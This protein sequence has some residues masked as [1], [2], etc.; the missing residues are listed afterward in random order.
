MGFSL[1][2]LYRS[3]VFTASAKL[4]AIAIALLVTVPI[5]EYIQEVLTWPGYLDVL[6]IVVEEGTE[7][8]AIVL[9]FKACLVNTKGLLGDDTRETYPFFE[10]LLDL[11]VF[12]LVVGLILATVFAYI[13]PSLRD[14]AN[15]SQ[16]GM[17]SAWLPGAFLFLAALA[18]VR[19]WLGRGVRLNWPTWG[20]VLLSLFACASTVASPD[21]KYIY[22]VQVILVALMVTLCL[23]DRNRPKA[24]YLPMVAI[25]AVVLAVSWLLKGDK[26]YDALL[27]ELIAIGFFY[28]ATAPMGSRRGSTT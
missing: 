3:H 9:L 24:T 21:A 14:V 7:I 26:V 5:Q 27:I 28:V 2:V 17:P 16:S 22:F 8:V 15:H 25:M 6:R 19:P 10:A 11:R 13:R 4:I 18:F 1:V 20:L 23:L 12:L